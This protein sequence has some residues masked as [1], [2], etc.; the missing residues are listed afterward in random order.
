MMDIDIPLLRPVGNGWRVQRGAISFGNSG[1]SM[2]GTLASADSRI[3][4]TDVFAAYGGA[5]EKQ[6]LELGCHELRQWVEP[7]LLGAPID[8]DDPLR[9]AITVD[10]AVLRG[11]SVRCCSGMVVT[12]QIGRCTAR[13]SFTGAIPAMETIRGEER[14]SV[15]TG[16][17]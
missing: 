8:I 5:L 11:L 12:F 2:V 13:I 4:Q 1:V 7:G 3:V 9:E 17:A 16:R 6:L 15:V 14:S 10:G